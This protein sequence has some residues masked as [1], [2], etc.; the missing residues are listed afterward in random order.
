[1]F[2][3]NMLFVEDPPPLPNVFVSV[4][5]RYNPGGPSVSSGNDTNTLYAY[6][7]YNGALQD[8]LLKIKNPINQ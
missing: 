2:V 3:E 5:F 6:L 1:M 7:Y 4:K 8:E